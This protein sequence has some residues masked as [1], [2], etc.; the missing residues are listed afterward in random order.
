MPGFLR[1]IFPAVQVSLCSNCYELL[2][3]RRRRPCRSC[4][5][6]SRLVGIG[7]ADGVHTVDRVSQ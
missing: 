2:R 5:C 4:G 6:T 7:I 1:R 3:E